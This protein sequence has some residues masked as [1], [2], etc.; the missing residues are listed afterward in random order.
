[1]SIPVR[2]IVGASLSEPHLT[3][4]Q[5]PLQ[6][7]TGGG[8]AD[9]SRYA[10][11]V[12]LP[13]TSRPVRLKWTR[14]QPLQD[15]ISFTSSLPE[16]LSGDSTD[17]CLTPLQT[18]KLVTAH[19]YAYNIGLVYQ[20]HSP[21]PGMPLIPSLNRCDMQ[22]SCILNAVKDLFKVVETHVSLRAVTFPKNFR[23]ASGSCVEKIASEHEMPGWY[24]V[25]EA[26]GKPASL[27]GRSI[28]LSK[29]FSKA[30]GQDRC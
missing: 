5:P 2:P 3:I 1:M 18:R 22:E 15:V 12:N 6:I 11:H 29:V 20:D 25:C 14:H 10:D 27:K 13:P 28:L 7:D 30:F 9:R 24:A 23:R 4:N 17:P 26:C 19:H 21:T 8:D 16:P